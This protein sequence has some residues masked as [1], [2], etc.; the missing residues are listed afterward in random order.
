MLY[1]DC[2][3]PQ[4]I[5]DMLKRRNLAVEVRHLQSGDY[6]FGNEVAIERKTAS[7]LVNSIYNRERTLWKQLETLKDTYPIP[8]LLVEG[9]SDIPLLN[10]RLLMGILT[11]VILSWKIQV[12]LTYDKV[13][14]V[15][16]I[17][18]LFTKYG[19]G[20]SGR[21]PPVAR[22][23]ANTPRE[24]KL[25]ML[26]Q[27][28]GVGPVMA[29]RILEEIPDIFKENDKVSELTLEDRLKRIKGLHKESLELILK[30]KCE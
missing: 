22:I 9:V 20:K 19:V 5:I 18:R 8:I 17:E 4:D 23:R 3:E 2:H 30:V 27:V 15:M 28:D 14:T 1:I 26:Q 24:I 25:A 13:E 6:V 11:T 7:D 29:N 21:E 10:D 12:I 16:W